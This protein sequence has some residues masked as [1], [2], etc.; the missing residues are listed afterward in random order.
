MKTKTPMTKAQYL[1]LVIFTIL[2]ISLSA[3]HF[4]L[5][6]GG[7][8]SFMDES[9]FP[10]L[11]VAQ[12]VTKG[13]WHM[14]VYGDI[15]LQGHFGMQ[16]EALYNLK[17]VGMKLENGRGFN[18]NYEY[19]DLPILFYYQWRGFQ[20]QVGAAAGLIMNHYFYD[21]ELGT[22]SYIDS[23]DWKRA[24]D[25]TA[26]GGLEYQLGRVQLGLRYEV[27]L[28]HTSKNFLVTQSTNVLIGFGNGGYHRNLM[29]SLGYSLWG[30]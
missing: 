22:N 12:F 26:L 16:I 25:V 10:P 30:K 17:G 7:N 15:P 23:G 29:L 28:S 21:R 18:A 3:Q 14:G 13:G 24:F 4:G 6:A 1:T 19:F 9:N 5:K 2:P 11:E 8:H 27:A 20:F